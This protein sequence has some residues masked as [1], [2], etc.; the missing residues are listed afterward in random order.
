MSMP[1]EQVHIYCRSPLDYL[2]QMA[3]H[4]Q[5]QSDIIT[6]ALDVF[7]H[8]TA[9]MYIYNGR[10]AELQLKLISVIKLL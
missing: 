3:Q 5:I 7:E 10:V 4:H 1:I 8:V 9:N 2:A 6:R